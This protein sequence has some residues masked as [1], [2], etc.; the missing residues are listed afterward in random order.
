MSFFHSIHVA[1]IPPRRPVQE[2][3]QPLRCVALLHAPLL[4]VGLDE[5]ATDETDQTGDSG[6]GTGSGTAKYGSIEEWKKGIQNPPPGMHIALHT[7]V[8]FEG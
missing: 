4:Q 8:C 5:T 3:L 1:P 2:S 6:K 7:P